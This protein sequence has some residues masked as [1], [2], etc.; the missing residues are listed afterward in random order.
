MFDDE[1]W[2]RVVGRIKDL[3][4]RGGENI[5]SAEVEGLL[6]A[7]PLVSQAVAVGYPDEILGERVAGVV[8]GDA[9]FD[10][11]ACREWFVE[12]GVA[13]FKTPE[14]IV[15]V[16]EMPMMPTGKPDRLALEALVAE[17]IA[18]GSSSWT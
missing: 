9:R 4:I 17:R 11:D 15:H 18:E 2:L 13:K 16:D 3:I 7:H 12:R 10:L 5:A 14:T 8:V 1:G 6:E